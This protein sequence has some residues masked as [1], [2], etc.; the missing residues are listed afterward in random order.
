MKILKAQKYKFN[1]QILFIAIM[2]NIY[3]YSNSYKKRQEYHVFF[4]IKRIEG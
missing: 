4:I 2:V 3:I 1:I